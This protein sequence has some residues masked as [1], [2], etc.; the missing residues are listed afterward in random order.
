MLITFLKNQLFLVFRKIR[1]SSLPGFLGGYVII[2]TVELVFYYEK[3]SRYNFC[4][5]QI[6]G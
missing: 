5:A 1:I 4:S 2:L 3:F 6:L